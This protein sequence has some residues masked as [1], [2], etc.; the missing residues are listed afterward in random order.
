MNKP[1][2]QHDC[3]TCRFLGHWFGH[4]VYYHDADHQMERNV[5][6]RYGDEGWEYTS[7]CAAA[8][9]PNVR[10]NPEWQTSKGLRPYVDIV[11]DK[12]PPEM[13]AMLIGWAMVGLEPS[14]PESST[15]RLSSASDCISPFG[16]T[17]IDVAQLQFVEY[18]Q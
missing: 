10:D 6:A 15:T 1:K 18:A 2:F 12:G 8:M 14:E 13:Q 7:M 4:D 3:D 9:L 17:P 16:S 5:V 11:M